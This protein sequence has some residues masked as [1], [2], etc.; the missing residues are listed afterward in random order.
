MP[1]QNVNHSFIYTLRKGYGKYNIKFH[2]AAARVY[3]ARCRSHGCDS[4]ALN[5]RSRDEDKVRK[6]A[7]KGIDANA[8]T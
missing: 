6:M 2:K 5:L 7:S 1:L 3:N 8:K 4:R